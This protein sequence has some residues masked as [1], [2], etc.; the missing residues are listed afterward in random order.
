LRERAMKVLEY[1]MTCADCVPERDLVLVTRCL[2]TLWE[3]ETVEIALRT[4]G[5]WL[6]FDAK[7]A[8]VF[9]ETGLLLVLVRH[10]ARFS[11]NMSTVRVLP[12]SDDVQ[13]Q[14]VQ[15]SPGENNWLTYDKSA[16]RLVSGNGIRV[17]ERCGLGFS[18]ALAVRELVGG[19]WAWQVT[20]SRDSK[21]RNAPLWCGV[22]VASREGEVRED[23]QP[24]G[25]ND[26]GIRGWFY[27][28][29]GFLGNG[30]MLAD[31]SV[32]PFWFTD[33]D[34]CIIGVEL[35]GKRGELSFTCNGHAVGARIGGVAGAGLHPAVYSGCAG[36]T[37]V[38]DDPHKA[39]ASSKPR[40]TETD[41][42]VAVATPLVPGP[43]RIGMRDIEKRYL[44]ESLQHEGVVTDEDDPN[45]LSYTQFYGSVDRLVNFSHVRAE[46]TGMT[47]DEKRVICDRIWA[48][49]GHTT[50]S[51][52]KST[53][54]LGY[55]WVPMSYT[56]TEKG[57]VDMLVR[58]IH[59]DVS[60]VMQKT[61]HVRDD[62]ISEVAADV[63]LEYVGQLCS[64]LL[65]VAP[66]TRSGDAGTGYKPEAS[67]KS[68]TRCLVTGRN[69][70]AV[71]DSVL[72]MVS[73]NSNNMR[74][75][76]AG[77]LRDAALEFL[78]VSSYREPAIRILQRL[79]ADD[80]LL[81]AD[82]LISLMRVMQASSP[83]DTILRRAII[84]CVD[85][86]R[87]MNEYVSPYLAQSGWLN[88]AVDVLGQI[89]VNDAQNS[90]IGNK[91]AANTKVIRSANANSSAGALWLI[92]GLVIAVTRLLCH[93]TVSPF[94]SRSAVWD[95]VGWRSLVQRA[96]E[97][98]FM[99]L[100]GGYT[101]L[102]LLLDLAVNRSNTL[103]SMLVAAE[104]G[105]KVAQ[106]S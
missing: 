101:V 37:F 28:D 26:K 83:R 3:E 2:D 7:Y 17:T 102:G 54:G 59:G 70:E 66:D 4:V 27:H 50:N 93:S 99:K 58:G 21:A 55:S 103:E 57:M 44:L 81:R 11:K 88:A 32:P 62:E 45:D 48:A 75:A 15:D 12:S 29:R 61:G 10:L 8:A 18:M 72:M 49:A 31:E 87:G 73:Q 47:E 92:I 60:R 74:V 42:A 39:P 106:V 63:L 46:L 33:D 105:A 23:A 13:V 104:K 40:A 34:K 91:S 41:V 85:K 53:K 9:R 96:E 69:F 51:G 38:I 78:R 76:R 79:V 52:L 30:E 94:S 5:K 20:I 65:T 43:Q 36:V 16:M 35:D 95:V 64:Q 19:S 68:T 71:T 84:D 97:G 89:V 98:G 24:H 25:D 56:V 67:N 22:G 6:N 77:G 90:A 86:T 1:V 100:G 82:D 14:A 80:A